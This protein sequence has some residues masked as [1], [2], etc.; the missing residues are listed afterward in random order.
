MA[1]ISERLDNFE[2]ILASQSGQGH[3]S[4][5]AL[6]RDIDYRVCRFIENNAHLSTI[7]DELEVSSQFVNYLQMAVSEIVAGKYFDLESKV[8]SNHGQIDSVKNEIMHHI[9]STVDN[10]ATDLGNFETQVEGRVGELGVRLDS[11]FQTVNSIS[12]DSPSL[13]HPV[14]HDKHSLLLVSGHIPPPKFNQEL[15]TA[16]NFLHELELYFKQKKV[17]PDERL[18]HLS[19]IFKGNDELELWWLRTKLI[20]TNWDGFIHDFTQMYGS[21]SDKAGALEK[22]YSRRQKEGEPF[23][24]FAL[25]M[26]VQYIKVNGTDSINDNI[27]S[28][29]SERA[30]PSLRSHLLSAHA[31]SVC[32]LIKLA[33]KIE[34]SVPVSST[35]NPS[36]SPPQKSVD[37]HNSQPPRKH[38]NNLQTNSNSNYKGSRPWHCTYCNGDYH[39]IQY[40]KVRMAD[41]ANA[42]SQSQQSAPPAKIANATNNANANT[43][44]NSGNVKK[45]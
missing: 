31:P 33:K 2:Q 30:L 12:R 29:I 3:D 45:Q 7:N 14:N 44:P 28:F 42:K 18:L 11:L 17:H 25:E 9:S 10:F 15:E 34:S 35:P 39:T 8:N 16:D 19:F 20:A 38:N 1:I 6:I 40:C 27:I 37:K 32:D 43:K 23:Q 4:C 41:E 5:A 22:L 26:E 36:S 24:K 13:T 21:D